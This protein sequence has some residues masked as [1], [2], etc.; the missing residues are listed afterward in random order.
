M[1]FYFKRG[2]LIRNAEKP[3][4]TTGRNGL[5][6]CISQFEDFPA[7]FVDVTFSEVQ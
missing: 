4:L 7:S 2:G 6:V 3:R 5:V 1:K